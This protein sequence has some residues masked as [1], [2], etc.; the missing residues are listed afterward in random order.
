MSFKVYF[1][2]SA[3]LKQPIT[4]PKGTLKEIYEHIKDTE[5]QL[6]FEMKQY[7]DN[8][9]HWRSTQPKDGVSDDIYCQIAE[10]HNRFVRWLYELFE[11]CSETPS[12]DGEIITP[13]ESE[14]FWHGLVNIDVPH[15]RWT[16]D[17]FVNRMMAFYEVMRGRETEG[18]IFE[19][20]KLTEKQASAVINIFSSILDNHD[21]RLDVPKG[22]DYLASMDDGGYYWCE[23]CGAVTE[24]DADN[25]TKRKCPIKAEWGE[26]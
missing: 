4:V 14:G 18:I 20:P 16:R 19:A 22:H 7:K 6:G 1:N 26:D 15:S 21:V 23:K 10:E 13:E 9:K 12:K 8:P 17:Y 3:G 5:T 25:C 11:R 24:E 2:L